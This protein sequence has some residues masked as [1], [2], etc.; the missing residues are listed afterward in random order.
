MKTAVILPCYNL[1]KNVKG[2]INKL[3]LLIKKGIINEI[4]AIDDFS[5]DNTL[6]ILKSFKSEKFLLIIHKKNAGKGKSMDDG[7]KLGIKR[8]IN[9]FVFFDGDGEHDISSIKKSLDMLKKYD[10]VFGSRFRETKKEKVLVGRMLM[11]QVFAC[12]LERLFNIT[13]TD[14]YCGFKAIK[15][16]AYKKI[17]PKEERY[18]IELEML[19]KSRLRKL[20]TREIKIPLL[21][22]VKWKVRYEKEKQ[23]SISDFASWIDEQVR[24]IKKVIK[25]EGYELNVK[26]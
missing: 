16:E 4:I 15:A 18:N 23:N 8:G 7:V 24:V 20:K 26:L 11:A 3:I 22:V 12:L 25:K 17:N 2:V 19:I 14:P 6:K 21:N 1:E 10:V 9:A 13:T 5:K